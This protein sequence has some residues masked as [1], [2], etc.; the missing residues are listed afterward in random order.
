MPADAFSGVL[1][2]VMAAPLPPSVS[3]I[4]SRKEP[5]PAPRCAWVFPVH[6]WRFLSTF[7]KRA[8]SPC[9][10]SEVLD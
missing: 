5:W 1:S 10:R 4:V 9:K 6:L 7:P 8:L 3:G 2:V